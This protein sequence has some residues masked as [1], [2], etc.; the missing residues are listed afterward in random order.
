[1]HRMMG[2]ET[3][4][5]DL[6]LGQFGIVAV[7]GGMIKAATLET[8]RLY[9]GRKLKKGKSFAFYR[10]DPPYKVIRVWTVKS[11][12]FYRKTIVLVRSSVLLL[13]SFH[14]FIWLKFRYSEKA[15]KFEKK[16]ST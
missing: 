7:H 4:H 16:S 2:E 3:I 1:M 15:T 9:T 13:F 8:I 10:V 12:K 6:Q 11:V 5:T 14:I